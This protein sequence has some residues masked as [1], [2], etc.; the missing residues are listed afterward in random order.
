[1]SLGKESPHLMTAAARPEHMVCSEPLCPTSADPFTGRIFCRCYQSL[2]SRDSIGIPHMSSPSPQTPYHG[3]YPPQYGLDAASPVTNPLVSHV[4]NPLAHGGRWDPSMFSTSGYSSPFPAGTSVPQMENVLRSQMYNYMYPAMFDLS[5]ARRKNATRET[6]S[7]LKAWLVEHKKNPYPTKAEKIMLAIVTKMTLTQVST[8]FANARRRLKKE[9]KGDWSLDSSLDTSTMSS[10]EEERSSDDQES[11]DEL[12]QRLG[13]VPEIS[14]N[15]MRPN[16]MTF[17]P[18]NIGPETLPSF[19]SFTNA[20]LHDTNGSSSPV[21]TGQVPNVYPNSHFF[22]SGHSHTPHEYSVM[23]QSQ[24]FGHFQMKQEDNTSASGSDDSD[25]ENTDLSKTS[26]SPRTSPDLPKSRIWSISDIMGGK[27][28]QKIENTV[29]K[30][31]LSTENIT[32]S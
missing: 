32:A 16:M 8:W 13:Q 2:E 21:M 15:Q 4:T 14:K 28:T 24:E 18:A 23:T 12:A 29:K 19:A 25:K 3:M 6:T 1:M 20:K 30:V 17:Q 9:T 31:G 11:K 7:A 5:G 10:D 27:N 26:I 22:Q